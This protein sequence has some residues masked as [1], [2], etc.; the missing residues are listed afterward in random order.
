MRKQMPLHSAI[1]QTKVNMITQF[2]C[3]YDAMFG[4]TV[5]ATATVTPTATN[6]GEAYASAPE[7]AAA[8]PATATIVSGTITKSTPTA[9][10]IIECGFIDVKI[11]E[12][13]CSN[14]FGMHGNVVGAGE[15]EEREEG[16]WN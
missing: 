8:P 16:K 10:T 13:I 7:S 9:D 12:L 2:C 4:T 6:I 3:V 1:H 15:E 5:P 11:L 14:F